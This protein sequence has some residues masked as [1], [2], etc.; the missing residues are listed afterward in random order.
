MILVDSKILSVDFTEDIWE[1]GVTGKVYA[2]KF[3]S[4]DKCLFS[5]MADLKKSI[6]KATCY[7]LDGL[8]FYEDSQCVQGSVMV[9]KEW[10]Q[11]SAVE[12]EQWK[13]GKCRLFVADICVYVKYIPDVLDTSL[14]EDLALQLGCIA[15]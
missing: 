6:E 7:T 8:Y 1:N 9:N 13:E 5:D 15:C 14:T 4:L 12:Q 11:C 2:C 10:E 3:P